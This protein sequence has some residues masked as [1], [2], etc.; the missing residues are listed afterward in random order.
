MR[1]AVEHIRWSWLG[2]AAC[3]LALPLLGETRDAARAERSAL[4]IEIIA[5][6]G[7]HARLSAIMDAPTNAQ[8]MRDGVRGIR[9]VLS[10]AIGNLREDAR[11]P[12]AELEHRISSALAQLD[13]DGAALA[14]DRSEYV[15]SAL[16][17]IA[18]ALDETRATLGEHSP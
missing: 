9:R 18:S 6:D 10:P 15:L 12:T 2:A 16:V 3:L 17:P 7:A 8:A 5:L 14:A 11:A 13:D 1:S 4:A